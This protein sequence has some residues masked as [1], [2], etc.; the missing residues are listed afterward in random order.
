M[1][2]E[3]A[4]TPD[5]AECGYSYESLGR[6]QVL[7]QVTSLAAEHAVLLGSVPAGR[8]KLHS[9]PGSWSALEY[10][11]HV[12]DVLEFQRQRVALAQA[13]DTPVFA[14]MRRDERAAEERY[15]DQNPVVVA[16]E[17]IAAAGS[18]TSALGDLSDV[19]WLRVGLY[20]WP[21]P[22]I[23]T[24]EWIGRRTVHELAHHLFDE[25]RLL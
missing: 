16:G 5:C 7:E 13:G 1:A 2:P 24:V 15:N 10:G 6:G 25:R 11:C 21:V 12:R 23:R 19:G 3:R 9:R 18:F 22:E 20:P 17:I 4:V 14:S 8:L